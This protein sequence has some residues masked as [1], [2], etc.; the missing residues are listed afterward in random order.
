M[1]ETRLG[2][3]FTRLCVVQE[4]GSR[5]NVK[6]VFSRYGDSRVKD[7]TVKRHLYIETA[8]FRSLVCPL[9][10]QLSAADSGK[11]SF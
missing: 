7:K 3:Y 4:P 5:L 6:T 2:S 1:C 8:R 11:G 10:C 9:L